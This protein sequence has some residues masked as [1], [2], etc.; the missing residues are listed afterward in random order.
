MKFFNSLFNNLAMYSFT[1]NAGLRVGLILG[2]L[3]G[4]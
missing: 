1:L 4:L 3:I 2:L